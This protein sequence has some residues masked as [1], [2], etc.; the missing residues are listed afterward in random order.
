MRPLPLEERL[1]QGAVSLEYGD[2][3]VKPWRLPVHEL[4][5]FP[6]DGIGGK[7]EIPAGVRIRFASD[8]R[9]VSL[10][11]VPSDQPLEVD[12]V[13]DGGP[14]RTAVLPAGGERLDFQE[15]PPGEKT[16]ELYLSQKVPMRLTALHIDSGAA[17]QI[18]RDPRPR[19]IAYGSSI[20]QCAGA[21]SPARTW[22]ALV[23][24]RH[25]L[26]LTCLGYGGNCHL[27]PMVARM[28]RD[29]PADLISLCVGINVYG[30]ASLSPR[31]F[32]PA[33]IGFIQILR[34]RHVE[35]PIIVQSPICS[36][37]REEQPNAVG[38]TLAAI[39]A[40]VEGAVATLRERG[41]ARLFYVN[42]LEVFG[43]DCVAHLPDQ[44]HPDAVGY[45]IMAENYSR[46]V[47]ESGR[48]EGLP[49]A[50]PGG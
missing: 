13:I 33:V 22:P 24:R 19:W 42:G 49:A 5:L 48:I 14:P 9:A 35:T 38:F 36:P 7:A 1:F 47:W 17:F 43:A 15:L 21:A 46:A 29:L 40:E 44:L 27:E 30:A 8:T 32:R 28:I 10:G 45:E 6:P 20:T 3:W 39:R 2:G 25:G 4:S 11:V 37:P 16:I 26:R 18:P 12:C 34:E 50:A 41:D 23:A 31:T